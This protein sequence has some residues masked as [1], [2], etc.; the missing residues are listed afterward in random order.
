MLAA[1]T[2]VPGDGGKVP[3][4][5]VL[6]VLP[7]RL[8]LVSA[9]SEDGAVAGDRFMIFRLAP[10]PA[11]VGTAEIVHRGERYSLARILQVLPRQEVR[12]G[13]AAGTVVWSERVGEMA[14]V[15]SDSRVR[16]GAIILPE[17]PARRPV[18]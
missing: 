3:R 14:P 13:D 4:G 9:G 6:E 10:S 7:E 16:G 5:I 2:P 17:L 15:R 12:A 1:G 11:Y 18:P 8:V